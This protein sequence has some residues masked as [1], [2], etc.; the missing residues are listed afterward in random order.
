M[1]FIRGAESLPRHLRA[2]RGPMDGLW[3]P[4]WGRSGHA[5]PWPRRRRPARWSR[6]ILGC[7]CSRWGLRPVTALLCD[8]TA[9]LTWRVTT[10]CVGIQWCI[11]FERSTG[12]NQFPRVLDAP[13]IW[14]AQFLTCKF[15]RCYIFSGKYDF[16]PI[17]T[18]YAKPVAHP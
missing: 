11:L 10:S 16:K 18:S 9:L 2:P 12:A 3:G 7:S 13:G 4:H 6:R 14:F 1:I 5:S 15:G 17:A 8:K